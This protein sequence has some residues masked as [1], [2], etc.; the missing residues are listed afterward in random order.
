MKVVRGK[1]EERYRYCLDY[2]YTSAGKDSL[3][4]PNLAVFR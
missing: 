3:N 2:I 4:E 1:V